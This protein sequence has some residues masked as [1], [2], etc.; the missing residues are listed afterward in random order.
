VEAALV[1]RMSAT[2]QHR[3]P[4]GKGAIAARGVGLGVRRLAI[5]DLETGDQP[6]ASE[7]GSV[8][9]VCNGEIYNAPELR[10]E[11]EANGHRFRSRSDV[12]VIVHLFEERGLDFVTRLRGMFALALWD[13]AERRLV[14][15]RD[16]FGIKP[17]VY[18]TAAAGLWFGSEAKAVLAGGGVDRAADPLAVRSLL[19]FGFVLTPRTLFSGIRRLPPAHLLVWKDGAATVRRYWEPPPDAERSTLGEDEWADALLAKLDETVRIH[20]RSDVEVGAWLSPGLDSSAI[21]SLARRALGRPLRSVTLAFEDPVADETHLHRTL[22]AY[23][24]F[25]LVNERAVCDRRSFDLVP[26]AVWHMEEPS[27]FAIEVPRLV[28]A[29]A[30]AAGV[31]VVVTGEGA[32]ELFGGYPYFRWN[33]WTARFAR[34]PLWARRALLPG[35]S[36]AARHPWAVPLLLAPR[37]MGRERYR[38]LVGVVPAAEAGDVLSGDLR[39]DANG[40]SSDD[41]CLLDDEGLGRLSPSA[42]LHRC[43]LAVRLPDYVLHTADRAAMACGLE[44]RVPFLD[45]ELAELCAGIP[46][47]L[48]SR[49]GIEKYILRRAVQGILPREICRRRKRGL[50]APTKGW[51]RGPLPGFAAYLLSEGSLRRS[52]YFDP[53]RVAEKLRRHRA[54]EADLG[55]VLGAV[56]GVQVWHEL[57]VERR[58]VGEAPPAN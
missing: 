27:A 14:L 57:F 32:D 19:E 2:L 34:V 41:G 52:G 4:D 5:I 16:R 38:R 58:R 7:D 55:Q 45:H 28:L 12:E 18:A 51:W 9:T 24:G 3:G 1:E 54:G 22:D 26:E 6:I 53:E 10:G 8:V 50:F 33:R 46:V 37:R 25:D 56:L 15:A 44:V 35:G 31:K 49:R 39:R 17:L 20:L 47:S 42:A 36:L 11:L 21:A 23:P 43:E 48:K 30:S 40:P 29:R 13:A